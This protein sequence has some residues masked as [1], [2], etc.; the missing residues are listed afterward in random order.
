MS[1]NFRTVTIKVDYEIS[2]S[3]IIDLLFFG[4]KGVSK[5]DFTAHKSNYM[6]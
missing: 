2:G 4:T 5:V 6:E 1:F 3:L